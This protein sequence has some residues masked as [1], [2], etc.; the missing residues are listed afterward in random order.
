MA[1][2]FDECPECGSLQSLVAGKVALHKK[3]SPKG[4]QLRSWCAG[5]RGAAPPFNARLLA[6]KNGSI[7]VSP[8]M[9]AMA[10]ELWRRRHAL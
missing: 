9:R 5:S 7:R 8:E 6:I 4:G 3:L 1:R 10:R 2:K